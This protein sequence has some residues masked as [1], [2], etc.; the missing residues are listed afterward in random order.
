MWNKG[1]GRQAAAICEKEEGNSDRYRRVELKTTVTTWKKSIGL[2]A[3]QEDPRA[4][5]RE[6][7]AQ[8]VQRFSENKEMD[9]VER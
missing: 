5:V 4:A 9:L 7:S 2:R 8:N 6:E 1:L 3:S